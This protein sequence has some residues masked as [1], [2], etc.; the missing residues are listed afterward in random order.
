MC[1]SKM[2][3]NV[4]CVTDSFSFPAHYNKTLCYTL[5]KSRIG[6]WFKTLALKANSL[7]CSTTTQQLARSIFSF[8]LFL[9][10]PMF[11]WLGTTPAI[12]LFWLLPAKWSGTLMLQ[13]FTLSS[14]PSVLMSFCFIGWCDATYLVWMNSVKCSGKLCR[15]QYPTFSVFVFDVRKSLSVSLYVDLSVCKQFIRTVLL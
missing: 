2:F 14:E 1:D 11:L 15:P 9:P 4:F 8:V 12:A 3:E 5:K 13:T 10:L 7:N 6:N